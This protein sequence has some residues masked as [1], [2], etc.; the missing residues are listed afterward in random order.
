[1]IKPAKYSLIITVF[2]LFGVVFLNICFK[3]KN[4]TKEF[5]YSQEEIKQAIIYFNETKEFQTALVLA[6]EYISLYPNDVEGWTHRGFAYFGLRDCAQATANLMHASMNGDEAGSKFL[7]LLSN[8][9]ICK[10]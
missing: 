5:P 6:N 8:N 4:Q 9:E 2:I 3:S 7:T 10:K 1:M